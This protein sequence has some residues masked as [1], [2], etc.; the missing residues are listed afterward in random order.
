MADDGCGIWDAV[1]F[2]EN[3]TVAQ[4]EWHKNKADFARFGFIHNP[5]RVGL[6]TL[7]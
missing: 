3:K 4:K 1:N 6:L 2:L 7:V 5:C